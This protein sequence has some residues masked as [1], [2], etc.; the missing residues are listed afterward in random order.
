MICF[1][2]IFLYPIYGYANDT[3]RGVYLVSEPAKVRSSAEA[4]SGVVLNEFEADVDLNI[5]QVDVLK[6]TLQDFLGQ[7]MAMATFTKMQKTIT[8]HYMENGRMFTQVFIPEQ[9]MLGGVLQLVVVES[10]LGE[11]RTEG[12]RYF[13]SAELV[14][15]M[16]L[17]QGE[18]MDP[19]PLE[20]GVEY[21][22]RNPFRRVELNYE[23]GKNDG[24]TDAVLTV[25][26]RF[27]IKPFVSW[28]DSGSKLTGN[29]RLGVGG[30]G[31]VH[32]L[33]LDHLLNYQFSSDADITFL[34]SHTF[35]TMTL[36][37]D[38]QTFSVSI[39]Y[40]DTSAKFEDPSLSLAGSSFQTSARYGGTFSDKNDRIQHNWQ[41][42][43]D[44]KQSSSALEYNS[45]RFSGNTVDVLQ[46][47][48]VSSL[49][50]TDE[51]GLTMATL[52]AFFSPG[53]ITDLND[54]QDYRLGGARDS[55][56]AYGKLE[57]TRM[58]KL[59][60]DWMLQLKAN[61]QLATDRLIGSEQFGVGGY[62]TVRGYDEREGN[63][64]NGLYA[65]AELQTPPIN[66]GVTS[67]LTEAPHLVKF[68]VFTDYGAT[69]LRNVSI[70]DSNAHVELLSVGTGLRYEVTE[71]LTVRL[72]YGWQLKDSATS[73]L[74]RDP[75][76]SRGHAGVN[77][78]Y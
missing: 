39:A 75:V 13:S 22:N 31:T 44:Y 34:K 48:W 40:A 46:M 66:L 3:L 7:P 4:W 37:P 27:P 9:A 30:T 38:N 5:P 67:Q 54:D 45:L 28:D 74:S 70:A 33:G 12:N 52:S 58:Q 69:A 60:H 78:S 76:S 16:R 19:K 14:S 77:L 8:K 65:S 1:C 42:G 11:I 10:R 20:E 63:G 35:S 23:K 49:L 24:T 50:R 51:F 73:S 64:D 47:V 62:A 72:D 59:P 36:L 57:L 41:A 68:L 21:L 25:K 61:A 2:T 29:H 53:N 56:Y 55:R 26:D 18:R 17:Q 15:A 32:V 6:K 43:L 71:L